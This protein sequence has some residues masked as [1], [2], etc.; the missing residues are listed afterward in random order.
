M[1]TAAKIISILLFGAVC[2]AGGALT[3]GVRNWFDPIV[4]V[5]IANDSGED[6]AGL[7]LVHESA[8]RKSIMTLPAPRRGA[9]TDAR[10]VAAGEGSYR[11][12]ATFADGRVVSSGGAYVEGGYSAREV[13]GRSTVTSALTHGL[14]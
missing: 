7:V 1:K 6:L 9:S 13:I 2:F 11:I 14:M 10:F 12:E 3:A 8:G 4:H 5:A